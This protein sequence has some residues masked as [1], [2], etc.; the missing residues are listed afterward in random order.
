M[1]DPEVNEP[2]ENF[3]DV[4]DGK[5]HY[6]DW[7]GTGRQAHLLHA[8][9]FCAGT[10]S[11]FVK[12]LTGV[13]HVVASDIRGHGASQLP[14]SQRIRHWNI[15]AEDLKALVEKA[16][17]PPIIGMGHSLGA[18][19]TYIAAAKYPRLFAGLILIDPTILPRR[20]LWSMAVVRM[21]GLARVIPLAKTARR[22]KKTF[23]SKKEALKRFASGRGIFKYWS[24]DFVEAYL[25]CG[26]LEKDP[27]TAVLKCDPEH[28]AQIFESV[29]LDVWTYAPNITCPVLAIRGAYSGAFTAD[30]AE[31]LGRLIPDFELVTIPEAGHFVPMGKPIEC[32]QVIKKFIQRINLH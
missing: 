19:T 31:R 13:L 20:I 18:V 30:A 23:Q 26:L 27:E 5:I 22:R 17:S 16:M 4:P 11:P 12:H 2:L 1:S 24:K 25:E 32:A 28:E 7:G 8:N 14:S 9:G 6:L 10:Y 29:P 21:L 3:I 15:F